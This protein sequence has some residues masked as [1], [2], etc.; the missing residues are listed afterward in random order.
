V[1]GTGPLAIGLPG[2]SGAEFDPLAPFK[3]L[4]TLHRGLFL[5]TPLTA[6]AVVGFV[7][8][9]RR[10]LRH[11]WY[12]LGLLTSAAALLVIHAIWGNFWDG[13]SSFSSRFLASL[14]PVYLIG[15]AELVRRRRG[16]FLSLFGVCVAW[17]MWVGLVEMNG[18]H[19]QSRDDGLVQIVQNYTGPHDYPP[20][21]DSPGNLVHEL[22]VTA[23]DRWQLLWRV[24]T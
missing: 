9:A 23:V 14:F 2:T 1:A 22:R 8:L 4:F 16:L 19:G 10:D 21:Y 24:S 18:Y 17:S 12:L 5:W 11:R 15:A 13:G 6:F 20:P 7:L 3:M